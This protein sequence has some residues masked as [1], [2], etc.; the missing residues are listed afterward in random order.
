MS[1][2]KEDVTWHRG[3]SPVL[4]SLESE[5]TDTPATPAVDAV[6]FNGAAIVKML[7]P[8]T[9]SKDLPGLCVDENKI[10][11]FSFL[12][13]I[14]MCANRGWQ[15]NLCNSWKSGAL[16]SSLWSSLT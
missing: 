4:Y 12:S 1:Q 10:E 3:R 6:F 7:S 13:T 8:G 9:Y 5:E 16:W 14:H 2:R 15:G 11:L